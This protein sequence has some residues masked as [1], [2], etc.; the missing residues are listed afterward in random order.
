MLGAPALSPAPCCFLPGGQGGETHGTWGAGDCL[1]QLGFE[2][3]GSLARWH[4]LS[5]GS[6]SVTVRWAG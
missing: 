2:A 4:P 5:W 6:P 3:A 1:E